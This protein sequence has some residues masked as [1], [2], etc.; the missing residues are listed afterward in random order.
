MKD[1][2]KIVVV[3]DSHGSYGKLAAIIRQ[4]LPF[5]H[6]VHCGDG[7]DDLD[8]IALP[9]TVGTVRVA[10]NMDSRTCY[11]ME[12]IIITTIGDMKVMVV[13]GDRFG[14][15]HDYQGLLY[16]GMEEAADMVFFGHTHKKY[17]QNDE[18][19]ALFNPGPANSG[20]YGVVMVGDSLEFC[21][22][23]I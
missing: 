11:G 3:S 4:E 9:A 22:K 12:R 10:G 15:V 20:V 19:P 13:H 21:H 6:L 23:K 5:D 2:V 7:A 16:K 17:L 18:K 14:V 8:Q 1:S